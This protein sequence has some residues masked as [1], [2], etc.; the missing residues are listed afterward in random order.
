V[1]SGTV[2]DLDGRPIP[3]ARLEIWQADAEG[4][5]DTQRPSYPERQLRAWLRTDA[6]AVSGS[7]RCG[8]RLPGADRRPAGV[9]LAM[10]GRHPYRPAH[11]HFIVQAPGYHGCDPPLR[12]RRSVPRLGRGI[13]CQPS[14]IVE[15]A[16]DPDSG[17]HQPLR[18][19]SC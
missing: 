18:T 19:R 3:G 13:R 8:Q 14:L 12:G 1:V 9:L 5:Y 10:M 17:V 11:I 7:G 4:L 15:L 16:R 6:E 2:K